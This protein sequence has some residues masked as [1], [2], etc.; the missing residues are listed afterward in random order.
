MALDSEAAQRRS[1]REERSRG[2]L[3]GG[4]VREQLLAPFREMIAKARAADISV[5]AGAELEIGWLPQIAQQT[6]NP[7]IQAG[8]PGAFSVAR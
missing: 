1:L 7:K 4:D 5:C 6:A 3:E 8:A 2:S